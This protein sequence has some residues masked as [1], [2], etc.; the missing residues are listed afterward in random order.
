MRL[1][2]YKIDAFTTKVFGGN[3]AAVCP[4]ENWLDDQLMQKI[5]GE[6]NLPETAFFVQK[7]NQFE[8]R[9]FTPTVEVDLCGHA[10]LASAYVLYNHLNYQGDIIHFHSHRSGAL[11]VKKQG[12][13]L[14]LNFPS[15]SLQ[16][17]DFADFDVRCFGGISPTAAFRGKTD[18][19]FTFSN[20]EAI[21]NM[22]PDFRAI[23]AI[24]ARGIIV[25]SKGDEVDFVS[26]FF[27]PQSGINED[28][29]TG[30]AHTSLTPYWCA[31]LGKK[32]M[33]ARQLSSRL[34]ELEC[35]L[36]DDRVEISG[37]CRLFLVGEIYFD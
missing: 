22:Q 13:T 35:N 24:P 6:N 25:T 16:E 4:L 18:Y 1:N 30:S 9:W 28:P 19:L 10:T 29:A 15:D 2:I 31:I 17:V 5:A 32:R 12:D 3:P 7:G 8:I 37:Q 34:G 27:G 33:T 23:A 20:E 36:L 14:T 11:L 21:A 26:R